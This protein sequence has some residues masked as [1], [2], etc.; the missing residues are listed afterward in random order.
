MITTMYIG[1]TT[2]CAEPCVQIGEDDY[3]PRAT[4]EARRFIAQIRKNYGEEPGLSVLEIKRNHHDHGVYISVEYRYDDESNTH[5][6]Y[7]LD[8]EGDVKGVL[9]H[10]DNSVVDPGPS[11]IEKAAAEWGIEDIDYDLF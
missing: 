10:W 1:D 11:D 4:K 5:T 7:G 9:E 2:P 3:V 8:I 6:Q